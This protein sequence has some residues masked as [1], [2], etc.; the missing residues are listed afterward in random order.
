MT[1]EHPPYQPHSETSRA[2]AESVRET[3]ATSRARVLECLRAH[4]AGLTDQEIQSELN[5]PGD[6]ERPRRQ[7]LEQRGLVHKSG[8][9]RATEKGRQADVWIAVPATLTLTNTL[10]ASP[11]TEPRQ[12]SL[13]DTL[14]AAPSRFRR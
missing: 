7:E 1:A 14:P 2:A 3:A 8:K 12:A 6:T 10:P 11:I 9:T 5:M 13:F 4:P